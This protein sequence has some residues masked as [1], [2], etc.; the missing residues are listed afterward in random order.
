M[1]KTVLLLLFCLS[2]STISLSQSDPEKVK[3]L[4]EDYIKTHPT[5]NISANT[6][7]SNPENSKIQ[8]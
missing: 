8:E 4:V 5:L 1:I 3:I 6:K 7:L 2:I